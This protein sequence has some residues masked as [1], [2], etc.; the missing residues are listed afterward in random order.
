M[1]LYLA[2]PASISFF[3]SYLRGR[4][5]INYYYLFNKVVVV[6]VVKKKMVDRR[7]GAFLLEAPPALSQLH[8]TDCIA[9]NPLFLHA[10]VPK[11][12]ARSGFSEHSTLA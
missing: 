9:Q 12:L 7:R 5:S 2:C 1:F 10:L 11:S 8:S 6:V 3:S 4:P